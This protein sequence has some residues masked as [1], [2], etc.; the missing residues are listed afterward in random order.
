MQRNKSGWILWKCV[1]KDKIWN[2]FLSCMDADIFTQCRKWQLHQWDTRNDTCTSRKLGRMESWVKGGEISTSA[3]LA[4]TRA[5]EWKVDLNTF[6]NCCQSRMNCHSQLFNP[7]NFFGC[8][9]W[10]NG[11]RAP[12]Q[13]SERTLIWNCFQGEESTVKL[14][15]ALIL[16]F[17]TGLSSGKCVIL[18]MWNHFSS[19]KALKEKTV[20]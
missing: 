6:V 11:I 3:Q 20:C 2:N 17:H 18:S 15:G 7:V 16:S 12:E 19:L 9:T 10:A 8:I 5:S 4:C 13:A 14:N 1:W